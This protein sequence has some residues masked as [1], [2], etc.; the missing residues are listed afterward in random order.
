MVPRLNSAKLQRSIDHYGKNPKAPK[1]K[2]DAMYD[3]KSNLSKLPRG[4]GGSRRLFCVSGSVHVS[5]GR[6]E[7]VFWIQFLVFPGFIRRVGGSHTWLV[8]SIC[9]WFIWASRVLVDWAVND[10]LV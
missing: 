10:T 7:P 2:A 4:G 5:P 1:R 9:V 6:W 8:P 3:E